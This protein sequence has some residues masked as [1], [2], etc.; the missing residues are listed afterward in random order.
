MGD[1]MRYNL[2]HLLLLTAVVAFL[3][4]ILLPFC[5]L[6][7]PFY[8]E[9]YNGVKRRLKALPNLEVISSWQHG[10]ITL[11]DCGF[12]IKIKD[13]SVSITFVDHQDWIGLFERIDGV[14]YSTDDAKVFLSRKHLSDAGIEIA[15]LTDVLE[16]LTRV[17]FVGEGV[18]G[19]KYE[20]YDQYRDDPESFK[21]WVRIRK[22]GK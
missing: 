1:Q 21:R 17:M 6:Y 11:E 15:G 12:D 4:V 20:I 3:L 10:A 14:Y 5:G 9:E 18:R 19:P 8:Y 16:H 22:P 2:R 7:P 13:A